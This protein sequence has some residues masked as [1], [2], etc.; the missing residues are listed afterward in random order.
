MGIGDALELRGRVKQGQGESEQKGEVE[1][2]ST[3]RGF[4]RP[5]NALKA[6]HC[7]M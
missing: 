3:S 5:H 6:N 1:E 2:G 7:V 4:P